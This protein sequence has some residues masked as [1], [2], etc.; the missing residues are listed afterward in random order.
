MSDDLR[1]H[2]LRDRVETLARRAKAAAKKLAAAPTERKDAVLRRVAEALRAPAS[3]AVLDANV[4]DVKAGED[5]GLS[6]A[7]LDRL[8]LDRARLD[9]V[10][11]AV[12]DVVRLPDPVGEMTES[13]RL[14]N[15]LEVGRMRAPL[16]LIGIIYESRPNVTVDA[17][18]L[19]F[20]A[21]NACLLR[22]G[23]EAFRTNQAL[24][25]IFAEALEAEGFDPATVS[26][27]PTLER[28]ATLIM[29]GLDEVLDLVIPR[30]G[31]GLIRFVAENARVPV[32]RHYKGVCHVYVDAD[33]DL[34][35]AR[36]IALNAKTHR[37]GVCNA[38]ETLLV[39]EAVA[40]R[41][42]PGLAAAM[43]EAGVELRGDARTRQLVPDAKEATDADWD[44][45]YLDLILA[46]RVVDGIDQAMQHVADHGSLHTEAIVTESYGKAQRWLREVDASLV[47]VNASTRFNDGGQLG[48]GAEVGISTTKLHAYGPMG[49]AE[50][51]TLKWVARGEG[52]IRS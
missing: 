28:E 24:A 20:K 5:A 51:C 4:A 12:E 1:D 45:E 26:L 44:E 15:G 39:D 31:E 29:I 7:L 50:L 10:A 36:A 32:I 42:L 17:A 3:A 38:M 33:A 8:K 47:L 2:D 22:G 13:R 41:F 23:K 52:Q 34:E 46:V 19:C 48:L 18:A 16:G 27:L 40:E 35:K 30:G 43:Q 37:P 14:A 25:A 11:A 49:L 21:G 9:G 6:A